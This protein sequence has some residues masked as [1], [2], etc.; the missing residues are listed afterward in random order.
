MAQLKARN[1]AAKYQASGKAV[2]LVGIEFSQAERQIVGFEW[3]R[4]PTTV[5]E[6]PAL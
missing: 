2:F 5:D 3:E 1:Y 6:L 4:C